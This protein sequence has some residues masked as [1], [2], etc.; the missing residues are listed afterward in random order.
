MY[1][2]PREYDTFTPFSSA[3]AYLCTVA[4]FGFQIFMFILFTFSFGDDFYVAASVLLGIELL[5]QFLKMF[6]F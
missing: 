4:I 2:Y 1:V 5:G 6:D 3:A